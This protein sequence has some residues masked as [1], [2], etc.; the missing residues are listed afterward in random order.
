MRIIIFFDS[1][2]LGGA[3]KHALKLAD[4]FK[5]T[6]GYVTEVWV[7]RHGADDEKSLTFCRQKNIPT[8]VIGETQRIARYFF[9]KQIIQFAPVF[10]AFKPDVIISFNVLPNLLNGLVHRFCGVQC[11]VWSQQSVNKYPF[12][13][14]IDKWCVSNITCFIS[15]SHHALHHLKRFIAI[16]DEK[17]FVVPNGI[18]HPQVKF[19]KEEWLKKL[20]IPDN[21]FKAVMTANLTNTKDHI[22]LIKA[23]KI[24]VAE[25][26]SENREAYLILPGRFGNTSH[27][28]QQAITE[29]D[30]F[31]F[32]KLP[33]NVEDVHGLNAAV[34]LGVLSSRAEGMPNG[35]MENMLAGIPVVGTDI[36]G[37][38]EVV[39]YENFQYLA[40]AG[41][42]ALLAE[43][44]LIFARDRNL[45]AMV[46]AKNKHRIEKEFSLEKM[47]LKTEAVLKKFVEEK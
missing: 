3:E 43:K 14:W 28:V 30:L 15:N 20:G 23:W 44:I 41:N 31:P 29:N 40:S 17:G 26:Q 25:L 46:G 16:A 22:T 36:D 27:E 47:C 33:G 4:F 21:S 42:A 6:R 7:M 45:S 34:D 5:N 10:R 1:Y 35:L 39:G 9:V 18:E 24:V 37:I 38:R 2:N 12:S 8:K 32:V 11:S 19:S 13:K